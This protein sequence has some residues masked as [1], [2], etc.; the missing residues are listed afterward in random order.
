MPNKVVEEKTKGAQCFFD[1]MAPLGLP[2]SDW[3]ALSID[4]AAA[5][6]EAAAADDDDNDDDDDDDDSQSDLKALRIPPRPSSMHGGFE[7]L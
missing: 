2:S 1:L 6:A 3:K 7:G 4:A 5:V